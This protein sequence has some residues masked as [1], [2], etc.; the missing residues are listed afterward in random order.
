[1]NKYLAAAFFIIVFVVSLFYFDL[2][3]NLLR[4]VIH[5]DIINFYAGEFKIDPLFITSLVKVESNFAKRA[6]SYRGAIG[7]MQIM[8]ATAKELALERGYN[9]FNESDLEDPKTNIHLG[10]YYLY[11][12][13][14]DFN[15][16]KIL[17]LAAYN[18]G[19]G[20]VQTWYRQNPLMQVE[21]NDIPYQE[22]KNY[23]K[24]VMRTYKWLKRAQE[25]KTL[26]RGKRTA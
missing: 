4:P 18:A 8:P 20:K 25:L 10:V 1:M 23:I 11:K 26:L 19:K 14:K 2:P 24:S 22:T 16:N 3:L 6:R 12:L 13:L 17:A 7:L 5:K 15:N 9:S 21:I